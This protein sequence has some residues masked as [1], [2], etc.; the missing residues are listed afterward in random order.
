MR[1]RGWGML[2][3]HVSTILYLLVAGA[4][5]IGLL[6]T[7][8][9]QARTRKYL[10][11][12][13]EESPLRVDHLSRP[14]QGLARETRALRVSLEGPIHQLD[15]HAAASLDTQELD[16]VLSNASRDLGEWV[17]SFTTLCEEDLITVRDLGAEPEKV[18]ALFEHEGWVLDRR[19]GRAHL[20]QRLRRISKELEHLEV[21]LQRQLD[22]Y[23]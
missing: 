9:T 16:A 11:E 5:G 8:R 21:R 4:A 20:A 1:K 22:P 18:Q 13:P 7:L 15:D 12:T 10:E 14:L 23:R 2:E 6:R 19:R 17:R 3:P